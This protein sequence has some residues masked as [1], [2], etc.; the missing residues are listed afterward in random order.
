MSG[1]IHTY[2]RRDDF[3]FPHLLHGNLYTDMINLNTYIV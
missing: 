2:E 1:E 3:Y